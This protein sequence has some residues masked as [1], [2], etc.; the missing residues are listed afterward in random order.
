LSEPKLI[1]PLLTDYIMGEALSEH[2]GVRCCPALHKE[3]ERKYI[4]KI[5]S[6]PASQ[7]QLEALLLAGACKDQEDALHYFQE[8]AD[9]TA[10]E[11]DL[12]Q[13]LSRMEGFSSYEGW[14]VVPMEDGVGFD[15][16]LLG[17]YRQTLERF[18]QRNPMTHLGAV[19]L[20]LDLCAALSVCR[21]NGY[22]YVDLKP[23]NVLI[24]D[25]QEYR[26]ADLGFI[27]LDSLKYASLPDKYRSA[28]TAPEIVDAYSSL[29]TTIDIYAAGLILYQAYNNGQLP[30]QEDPLAPPAY[31]DYEMAEIILKAC[32]PDPQQRW[33]DPEQMGQAL[34]GYM[35]R[36]GANDTPIIPL[37]V[38][39][40]EEPEPVEAEVSEEA[41]QDDP[42]AE[43]VTEE[44]VTVGVSAEEATEELPVEEE[45]AEEVAAAIPVLEEAQFPA[46]ETAE[47][48]S[49][50]S[51]TEEPEP[52]AEETAEEILP[53]EETETS[54]PEEAPAEN[55]EDLPAEEESG[56]EPEE[57]AYAPENFLLD[58]TLPSDSDSEQIDD[59]GLTDE[60]SAMLAQADDLIAHELPTPVV[61]PEPIDVPIPPRIPPEPETPEE[62]P[63][64][65]PAPEEEEVSE[66]ETAE[67]TPAPTLPDEPEEALPEPAEEQEAA[68]PVPVGKGK[69][70]L[71]CLITIL[72]TALAILILLV[73]AKLFYQNY[74]LQHI[75]GITATGNDDCLTIV[76]DTKIDNSLLTA[77][78]T[79]VYGNTL[80]R[81][82]ENNTAYFEGLKFGT[83]YTVTI[84][85]SGFHQLVGTTST[86]YTTDSQTN[87]VSFTAITGDQDGS[88]IL[89]FS[90]QEPVNTGWFI[91]YSAPGIAEQTVPCN[92][93]VAV[94]NDLVVGARYTFR[95]V[96]AADLYLVGSHT[97]E[98]TASKVILP[99][100]LTI[101][102][103][104]SNA[105][106]VTWDAPEGVDVPSWTV[107]CY[108][109]NGFDTT[110]TVT[111]P[112][113][114]FENL[115]IAS[116]YT[117]DVQAEGMSVSD[118]VSVSAKSVTFK[119]ILLDDSSIGQLLI[120]WTYEGSAPEDG[121]RLFYT[122]DGGEKQVIHCEKNT[123]TISP[124]I[125]G[126]HYEI[127]F[128]FSEDITVFGGTTEYD[129]QDIGAFNAYGVTA[130]DLTFRMCHTPNIEN[131][132]WFNLYE[133]QFTDTYA[134]NE[135]PAFVILVDAEY[136]A[137]EDEISTLFIV[138][139]S[140]SQLVSVNQGPSRTWNSMWTKYRNRV[141]TEYELPSLPQV[142][143]NYT[144]EI[145]FNS[146]HLTTYN[147]TVQ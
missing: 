16:Y 133:Y 67:E 137:S 40:P 98:Y 13:R 138:R 3:S 91:K 56:S 24:T 109:N 96:P 118:Q 132:K 85:I 71:G 48:L 110:V 47:E 52:A 104:D 75:L 4:V 95:L 43:E 140:N 36:N 53:P 19:N 50:A 76:L 46:E 38:T 65:A 62:D 5:I 11:A 2:H 39:Q 130:E 83:T 120:T 139:D 134:A 41:P 108:N 84:K 114:R 8:L 107:R 102:G 113:A 131:W 51:E 14:Q 111:E 27:R 70:K 121:W 59:A 105:L 10:Q 60:V 147:F 37:P 80:N 6:I 124:L 122:V 86:S 30:A 35:Q 106:V 58:E 81:P 15:V 78:C 112:S 74:Y 87:I 63:E 68:E 136:E 128:E 94:I 144:V 29:N 34:V 26:I 135:K 93:H 28:Y 115:D 117:V 72:A 17:P 55:S 57:E 18:F 142:P 77:H 49:E 45:S 32:N 89:N 7:V 20:G 25:S 97:L 116:G 44:E 42:V 22:L 146:A 79:D 54:V 61:A 101:K 69:K 1:S 23:G 31:A 126:G 9:A 119:D 145:Y 33:E 90:V 123:C 103:F 127:S 82:V 129:A 12:L 88:V 92:G 143:G 100:N 64:A 99:E 21:R 73:G 141:G 66:P 125:P